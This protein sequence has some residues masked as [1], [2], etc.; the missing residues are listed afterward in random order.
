M[1]LDDYSPYTTESPGTLIETLTFGNNGIVTFDKPSSHYKIIIDLSS[2]PGGTGINKYE[3]VYGDFDF[4]DKFILYPVCS[5]EMV[6]KS[7]LSDPKCIFYNADGIP[8]YCDYEINVSNTLSESSTFND[9]LG[10]SQTTFAGNITNGKTFNFSVDVDLEEFSSIEKVD[11]FSNTNQISEAEKIEYYC[12]IIMARDFYNDVCLNNVMD[13]ISEFVNDSANTMSTSLSMKASQVLSEPSSQEFPNYIENSFFRIHYD[14]GVSP[15]IARAIA[16]TFLTFKNNLNGLGFRDPLPDSYMNS[17]TNV[18]Y[19][20]YVNSATHSDDSSIAGETYHSKIP[21]THKH[22][23]HI[24]LYNISTSLTSSAPET[25]AHEFFHAVQHAYNG[26]CVSNGKWFFESCATWYSIYMG[27]CTSST[28]H[29]NSYLASN[30]DTLYSENAVYGKVLFPL[31][32]D[33]SYG[34]VETL[35]LIYSYLSVIAQNEYLDFSNIVSAINYAIR[36]NGQTGTFDDVFKTF[37][38]YNTNPNYY[39]SSR[40]PILDEE[41]GTYYQWTNNSFVNST[42]SNLPCHSYG[43]LYCKLQPLTTYNT[44]TVSGTI[45][46]QNQFENSQVSVIKVLQSNAGTYTYSYV[47]PNGNVFPISAPSLGS[48]QTQNIYYAIV[49]TGARNQVTIR[50]TQTAN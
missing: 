22:V 24:R 7:A 50:S 32:I 8:V 15:V 13:A 16:S 27:Y 45:T 33:I 3:C 34:G 43:I 44:Y 10:S 39:Y 31:T 19:N 35:R 29:I 2:L 36:D 30:S 41:E 47:Q 26:D 38:R 25:I 21:N 12:D 18:K 6:M 23:S 42:Y 17:G 11:F 14:S 37:A 4:S 49:N 46:F 1:A 40:I 20:V 9:I 48:S 5:A 28:I